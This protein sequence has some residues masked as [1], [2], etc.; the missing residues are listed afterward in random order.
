MQGTTENSGAQA[1]SYVALYADDEPKVDISKAVREHLAQFL[2][3]SYDDKEVLLEGDQRKVY[4][5]GVGHLW[6]MKDGFVADF[7][8]AGHGHISEAE[9]N[10]ALHVAGVGR[11]VLRIDRKTYR[12]WKTTDT[13]FPHPD[14]HERR[15]RAGVPM[16]TPGGLP[17]ATRQS[18][19]GTLTAQASEDWEIDST[20]HDKRTGTV[21]T[22]YVNVRTQETRIVTRDM[23]GAEIPGLATLPGVYFANPKHSAKRQAWD[24]INHEAGWLPAYYYD[25]FCEARDAG[26]S[27]ERM[28][29]VLEDLL[30]KIERRATYAEHADLWD[31]RC[32]DAAEFMAGPRWQDQEPQFSNAAQ[33]TGRGAV[34][35]LE[36]QHHDL[37]YIKAALARGDPTYATP[38]EVKALETKQ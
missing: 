26:L 17:T 10:A 28:W 33:L 14:G 30:E 2:R 27:L 16:V 29:L 31:Y 11:S 32:H 22:V 8:A 36:H 5:D 23:T 34:A 21:I 15:T 37:A 4:G 35:Q 1:A 7:V 20:E 18:P 38:A 9:V 19:L 24:C 3:I 12:T 25:R 13:A 6:F